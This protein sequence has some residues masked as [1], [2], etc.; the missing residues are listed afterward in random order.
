METWSKLVNN[1]TDYIEQHR[2]E[3]LFGDMKKN[4][5]S[6]DND[7]DKDRLLRRREI[8]KSILKLEDSDFDHELINL[9]K[10]KARGRRHSVTLGALPT[11]TKNKTSDIKLPMISEDSTPGRRR[12]ASLSQP[13]LISTCEKVEQI[14]P[15]VTFAM[16]KPKPHRG[17][18]F[19]AA[20]I[21]HVSFADRVPLKFVT[22][23]KDTV[24]K[25]VANAVVI[26][27][28]ND[29][30]D[31]KEEN[32][33]DD[34]Q[35]RDL[36]TPREIEILPSIPQSPDINNEQTLNDNTEDQHKALLTP[37]DV[38]P[39]I[40]TPTGHRRRKGSFSKAALECLIQTHHGAAKLRY[41]AKLAYE[42]EKDELA[43]AGNNSKTDAYADLVNCRYL[44]CVPRSDTE[45]NDTEKIL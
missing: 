25:P 41:I 32:I 13:D 9:Q 1:E 35:S 10:V 18:R 24:V 23:V 30:S 44:R 28:D 20:D 38:I 26:V 45:E 31:A 7:P 21:R 4:N 16:D 19:S 34:S 12:R 5:D 43:K 40:S 42:M 11:S 36:V 22:E 3:I 33:S 8:P 27:R 37:I 2:K 39:P 14:K 17:R 29:D 15:S 6:S